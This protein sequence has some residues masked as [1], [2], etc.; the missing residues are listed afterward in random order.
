MARLTLTVL[1]AAVAVAAA[2]YCEDF[3]S[4]ASGS[5]WTDNPLDQ[6]GEWK[7]VPR[8]RTPS[9]DPRP[10]LGTLRLLPR[11][12]RPAGVIHRRVRP[13][14]TGHV[15]GASVPG[16]L[17]HLLPLLDQVAVRGVGGAGCEVRRR[18]G[19]AADAVPRSGLGQRPGQRP[20]EDGD[21]RDPGHQRLRQ[22]ET[23]LTGLEQFT[24]FRNGEGLIS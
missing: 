4:G 23:H 14:Q 1:V 21:G 7:V 20:V 8:L 11:L 16:R 18:H 2:D 22:G 17:Q 10:A 24:I 9:H 13:R 12:H 19:R 15:L 5:F 3:E 6:A